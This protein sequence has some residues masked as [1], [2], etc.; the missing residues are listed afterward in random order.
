[1]HM[2]LRWLAILFGGLADGIAEFERVWS[3]FEETWKWVDGSGGT[4]RLRKKMEDLEAKVWVLEHE[5]SDR[6]EDTEKRL[7]KLECPHTELEYG[8][9]LAGFMWDPVTSWQERCK[10]CGKVIRGLSNDE[11]LLIEKERLASELKK[12]NAE[13]KANKKHVS[14][15]CSTGIER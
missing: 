14:D 13:I 6:A 11:Y 10:R 8:R 1:M 3:E 12:V 15:D 2:L 5:A 7:S 4:M 9:M